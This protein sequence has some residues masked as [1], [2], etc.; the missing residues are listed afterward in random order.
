MTITLVFLALLM[1]ALLWWL[2]RQSVNVQ[3]WA[4]PGH[5][6]DIHPG[7]LDRPAAKTALWVF[8]AVVTSLFALF[9]SAYAMRMHVGDWTHLHKPRLLTLN[10]IV[11][12]VTSAAMHWTVLA[13]RRAD[14]KIVRLGVLA[15]GGLTFAFLIGQFVVW[16]Q[17]NEAG[18]YLNTNPSSSFFFM[19]TAVHALHVIG[20]LIAWARTATRVLSGAD[21]A[22]MRLGVELC[23]IYWHF[24]LVVWL[25]LF[26]LLL[27][28]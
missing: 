14:M 11:L 24:L 16:R 27:S 6:T 26:A 12:I 20:G 10:T 8:L 7:V 9:I 1:G 18:V 25:V 2:F 21:P 13:A 23:A 15:T 19:L 22:R 28:T 4:A 17:L 5:A 3:P